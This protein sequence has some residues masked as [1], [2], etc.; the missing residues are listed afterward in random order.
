LV[1]IDSAS[2]NDALAALVTGS[3][4]IGASDQEQEGVFRW[5][6]GGVVDY[7]AWAV[8]QPDDWEG[9]EDCAELSGFDHLWNDRPCTDRFAKRALCEGFPPSSSRRGD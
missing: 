1:E 6:G 2:D 9:R 4:W 3:V 7:T 8:D 5:V